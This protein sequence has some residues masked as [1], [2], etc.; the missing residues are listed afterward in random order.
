MNTTLPTVVF[1]L[2]VVTGVAVEFITPLVGETSEAVPFDC[3]ENVN[4]NLDS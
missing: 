4:K 2:N 3:K 1:V